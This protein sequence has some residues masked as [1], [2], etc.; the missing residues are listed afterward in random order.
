MKRFYTFILLLL[1]LN[2]Y[3]QELESFDFL[4]SFTKDEISIQIGISVNYGV[5]LYKIRYYT[6]DLN[7][8]QHIASGL[9]CVPQSQNLAFPLACYQH[10][11]ILNGRDDVPSNLQG[12]YTLALVFASYG[13]VVCA[14]DLLGLGDSPGIHPY[15]H[16]KSE[17]SAS[18]DMLYATIEMS[19]ASE[20]FYLNDQLFISG[21]S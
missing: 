12:G 21:Y 9:L 19:E 8:D 4:D 1:T 2:A 10:G 13:Y 5:D 15:I 6:P 16:A 14:P 7:G 17:A 20:L 18:V 11:T 3:S